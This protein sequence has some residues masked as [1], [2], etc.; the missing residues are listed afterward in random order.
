MYIVLIVIAAI[1]VAIV[2][3]Y[4]SL[5][6]KRNQVD[7]VFATT[8]VMLKKRYDLVPN[9]V[10]T[11]KGYTSHERELLEEITKLRAQAMEN[12]GHADAQV[13][14]DNIFGKLLGRLF[15]VVENYPE[16]KASDNY[17]HLQRTLTELEEQISAARRAYNAAVTDY[18]TAIQVFPTNIFATM[19][20]FRM[21][22]LFET[23]EEEKKVV[24]AG[25]ILKR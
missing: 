21:R 19:M 1:L 8:D 5:I 4:N 7:N 24:D 20:N 18:N 12:R 11:V 14:I 9:L 22:K 3:M 13:E 6:V 2:L 23:L 15:M 10:N 25:E 17:M 16:L